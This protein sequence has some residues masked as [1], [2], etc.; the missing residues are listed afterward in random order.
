MRLSSMIGPARPRPWS[1]WALVAGGAR[2]CGNS[3]S[4][5]NAACVRACP[6]IAEECPGYRPEEDGPS[7]WTST[8]RE[9]CHGF[10]SAGELGRSAVSINQ[11]HNTPSENPSSEGF[12]MAQSC[13]VPIPA[14]SDA[15]HD[16]V[17]NA[18]YAREKFTVRVDIHVPIP[19]ATGFLSNS[20]NG[21]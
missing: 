13:S 15:G 7:A 1:V 8:L 4:G 6:S 5:Q 14:T 16:A 21:R 19:V 9:H 18:Q 3:G 2:C 17:D 10:C 20:T 11:R 12:G